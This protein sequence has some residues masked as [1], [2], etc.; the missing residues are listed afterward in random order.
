MTAEG[1]SV[2]DLGAPAT[3]PTC[4]GRASPA[5]GHAQLR[6][7]EVLG[8]IPRGQVLIQIYQC[9]F[10]HTA[11]RP[12]QAKGEPPDQVLLAQ[13][14]QPVQPRWFIEIDV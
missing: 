9:M 4:S 3:P 2:R 6:C 1:F 12:D 11:Q 10:E 5:A 13:E 7:A 14:H 8:P